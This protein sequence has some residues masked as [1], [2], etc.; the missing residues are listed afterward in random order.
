[1]AAHRR[2][3]ISHSQMSAKGPVTR[4]FKELFHL[5]SKKANNGTGEMAQRLKA[6]AALPE[7]PGSKLPAPTWQLTTTVTPVPGDPVLF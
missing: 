1:M 5:K 2:K 6:L 3:E 7:D 4:L